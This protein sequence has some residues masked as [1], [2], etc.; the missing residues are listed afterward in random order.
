[1]F[2]TTVTADENTDVETALSDFRSRC[3]SAS[4]APPT[5]ELLAGQLREILLPLVSNGRMLAAQGSQLKVS[6]GLE[7]DGCAVQLVFGSGVPRT[8]WRR[9][10]DRLF[11]S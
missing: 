1:V 6:R 10:L 9:V 5:I 3:E 11:G 4:V 7:A 2:R 8:S